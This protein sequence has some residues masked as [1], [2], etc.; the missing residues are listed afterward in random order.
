MPFVN[1]N[2]LLKWPL[3]WAPPL[4]IQPYPSLSIHPCLYHTQVEFPP[5]VSHPLSFHEPAFSRFLPP[6]DVFPLRYFLGSPIYPHLPS[7]PTFCKSLFIRCKPPLPPWLPNFNPDYPAT[8][9]I[10]PGGHPFR[11]FT[12]V[13]INHFDDLSNIPKGRSHAPTYQEFCIVVHICYLLIDV[14]HKVMTAYRIQEWEAS[15][16]LIWWCSLSDGYEAYHKE[17]IIFS[18]TSLQGMWRFIVRVK[19]ININ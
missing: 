7:Q 5:H 13:F 6:W 9:S 4:L 17:D 11:I 19:Y 2:Y 16:V 15:Y 8:W 18:T 12:W 3:S 1:F 14:L 10:F